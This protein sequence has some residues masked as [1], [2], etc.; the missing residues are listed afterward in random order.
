MLL[1]TGKSP[2]DTLHN[3]ESKENN[4]FQGFILREGATPEAPPFNQEG[5]WLK[6]KCVMPLQAGSWRACLRHD[7]MSE[8]LVEDQQMGVGAVEQSR[9]ARTPKSEVG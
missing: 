4:S 1:Q 3:A 9:E 2:L 6:E 7:P 8:I 5:R